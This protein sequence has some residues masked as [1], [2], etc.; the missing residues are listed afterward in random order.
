MKEPFTGNISVKKYILAKGRFRAGVFKFSFFNRIVEMLN[1]LPV[2]I[3]TIQQ[4]SPLCK[5]LNE[6]LINLISS[7]QIRRDFYSSPII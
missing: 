6:F 3:R 5:K 1:G 2:A 4:L 7:I